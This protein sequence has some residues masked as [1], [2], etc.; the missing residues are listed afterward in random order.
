MEVTDDDGSQDI[1]SRV[2]TVEKSPPTADYSY[3]RSF[4]TEDTDI[5]FIDKS[6][7][8]DGTI[9]SWDWDFGDGHGSDVQNPT[10]EYSDPGVYTVTL[11]VLDEDGQSSTKTIELNVSQVS[12]QTRTLT[13]L[14]LI[15][16]IGTIIAY[17][18]L[19]SRKKRE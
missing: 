5:Q 18:V 9:V 4:P 12:F 16:M 6:S 10:H 17:F 2:V 19:S 13:A 15:T 8:P 14:L 11:K 3:S 7:D 1:V